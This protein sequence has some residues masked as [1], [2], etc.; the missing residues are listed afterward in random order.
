MSGIFNRIR[1]IIRANMAPAAPDYLNGQRD[2]FNEKYE[3]LTRRRNEQKAVVDLC[4]AKESQWGSMIFQ[5]ERE[6]ERYGQYHLSPRAREAKMQLLTQAKEAK[7]LAAQESKMH[8]DTMDRI[9][10]QLT[11]IESVLFRLK[12]VD[13]AMEIQNNLKTKAMALHSSSSIEGQ[14]DAFDMTE[15]TR[16]L[17]RVEYTTQALI[18]LGAK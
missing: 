6:M 2:L 11:Q 4:R 17:R 9:I 7:N 8:E 12:S 1:N 13:Y 16:E 15:L 10:E 18:E 3:A 5:A 14:I